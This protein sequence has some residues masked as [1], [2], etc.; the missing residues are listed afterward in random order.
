MNQMLLYGG[1]AGIFFAVTLGLSIIGVVT[2]ER[3]QVGRSLDALRNSSSVP[4]SGVREVSF[5]D[6][7]LAP[8]IARLAGFSRRFSPA[9]ISEKIAH[10]LDLAGNPPRWGVER[11]LAFKTLG[12]MGLGMFGLM[13]GSGS[14]LGQGVIGMVAGLAF[15]FYLP[16]VLVYNAG[17]RR[18]QQIRRSLPDAL[19]LLTISVEAGLGFDAALTQVARNTE[20]PFAAELFR[21]QQEMQ[22]GTGRSEAFRALGARTDVPELNGFIT[23][24]IQAE[25][26]G[27]PIASVLR[28]QAAEMRLKR[29]Q[30]AEET[31]Q[32]VPVKILFPLIFFILP[33][34]FVVIIGP[35]A[36][37]IMDA[38]SGAK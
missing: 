2:T 13:L 7:V 19:D 20:G 5:L 35:G 8:G 9:G 31:A 16:D 28:V 33:A 21:M 18:Q 30:R 10:R 6:R 24:M 25:Q 26:F 29:H 14:G 11:V 12:L 38:F 37:S 32:K 15:G 1:L 17:T 4:P 34:L 3:Q 23:A 36:L 27:I 22:I